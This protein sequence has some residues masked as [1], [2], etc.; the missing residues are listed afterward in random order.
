MLS[1][2]FSFRNLEPRNCKQL[3][4]WHRV[5]PCPRYQALASEEKMSVLGSCWDD[6]CVI[7]FIPALS[8][9]GI[10]PARF[11]LVST[12]LY[13]TISYFIVYKRRMRFPV[14]YIL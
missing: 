4:T 13:K 10:S 2:K 12:T 6:S 11:R 9:S 3:Q 14:P 8:F 5:P 1:K 7:Y